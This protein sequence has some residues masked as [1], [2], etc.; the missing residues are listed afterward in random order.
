MNQAAASVGLILVGGLIGLGSS[1]LL[2]R[3][4]RRNEIIAKLFDQYILIRSEVV[5]VLAELANL[6]RPPGWMDSDLEQARQRVSYLFYRYYDF[7]PESVLMDLTCLDSCLSRRGRHFYFWDRQRRLRRLDTQDCAQVANISR[8]L[9]LFSN[10]H[11]YAVM[12]FAGE[13]TEARR[14][15]VIR[16]QARQALTRLN[17][18]FTLAKILAWSGG[19][20]KKLGNDRNV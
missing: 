6:D 10:V 1:F 8:S 14:A 18:E 15:A 7:L 12:I 17:N 9:N 2:E 20:R 3:V 11:H 16:Y 4:R 13:D 5:K 19:L